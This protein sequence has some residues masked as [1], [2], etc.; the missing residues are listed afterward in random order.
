MARKSAQTRKR[1]A[2][3]LDKRDWLT[4]QRIY[5]IHRRRHPGENPT[6]N[7]ALHNLLSLARLIMRKERDGY[8]LAVMRGDRYASIVSPFD[9]SRP[10]GAGGETFEYSLSSPKRDA[11]FSDSSD[12]LPSAP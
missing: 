3:N 11:L 9:P 7:T 2:F 12:G 4:L 5:R 10:F 8:M 1:V 6:L